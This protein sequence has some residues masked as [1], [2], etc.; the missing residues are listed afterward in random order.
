MLKINLKIALRNLWKQKGFSAINII[1]LAVGLSSCLLILLFVI[2]ENSYDEFFENDEHIFR[3]VEHKTSPSGEEIYG[4]APY[5]FVG[6]VLND[7]PEV[8]KATAIAGPF[9]NQRVSVTNDDGSITNFLE[10]NVVL[11]D[12]SFFEVFSF[13]LRGG[14]RRAV[15]NKPNS[16]VLTE[17]T[18]KRYYGDENAIGKTII[19]SGRSSVITGVCEDPPPNSHF[20]FSYLVSST[21]VRWFSQENFN[22]RHAMCYFKLH[23]EANPAALENK[24]PQMVETY[25]AEEIERVNNTSWEEFVEAGNGYRFTLQPL[26][27]IYL[28]N[29]IEGSMKAGGNPTML[30][31]LIAVALLIF[32]IAC[33]NFMNLSTVRA[34]ERSKEVGVRK[35][36][37]SQKSQ[38]ILQFLTESIFVS[39]LS[40]LLS[41]LLT[42][43][44]IQKFNVLF[45]SAIEL[46]LNFPLLASLAS[47]I[48]FIS[49]LAGLYPAFVIS[50]FK[51]VSALKGTLPKNK[52]LWIKNGLIGFQFFISSVLIICSLIGREQISFLESKNLGY[53]NDLQLVIEG[54]FHMDAIYTRPFLEETKTIPGVIESAGSLWVP[55]FQG[56][57]SDKYQKTG[58]S[59]I[60]QIR[61]VII[62][63][64]VDKVLDF[65]MVSGSFFSK[66]EENVGSVVLNQSAVRLFNF[67]NPVGQIIQLIDH[68]E[69]ER[70]T[71][72]YKVIGVIED[73]NYESLHNE[74]EPLVIQSSE[75]FEGRMSYILI[76]LDGQNVKETIGMLEEKW[77][78]LIPD[79]AF[80][81]RFMDEVLD[82]KYQKEQTLSNV[83]FL[84]TSLSILIAGIGLFGLAAYS[85]K[86]RMKEIGIRKVIGA[87]TFNI[88]TLLSK[89]SSIVVLLAFI[90]SI[91][92]SYYF[93]ENWLQNFVYRINIPVSAFLVAGVISMLIGLVTVNV[94]AFKAA[95]MNPVN[96]LKNE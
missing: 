62:G 64:E 82:S 4:Y 93:A 83:F 12:S 68:D 30:N 94:I 29:E 84:F 13:K 90:T 8:E 5:S 33:I 7:Y 56:T 45:D 37:G 39:L 34:M 25:L 15:L 38:L 51:P 74:I 72:N 57:W 61:R 69:G 60:Y 43:A 27:T 67:E 14:S 31:V 75:A 54:T 47:V 48:P 77:E 66:V 73:F 32:I 86:L 52:S 88:L 89:S 35:V 81:F 79:R 40:T 20:K 71:I 28:D 78:E 58:S 23:P 2:Y 55:G 65:E 9:P 70:T 91:P 44:V 49:I 63:D 22:L 16:V 21:T 59:D 11:A 95:R 46:K 76:K 85:T 41:I 6:T 36:M 19:V 18:A 3:M 92:C 10:G 87:S 80:T 17:S 50:S 24:F 42:L 96:S 26:T 53:D 1:G